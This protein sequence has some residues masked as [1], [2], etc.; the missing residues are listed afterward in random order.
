ME[1]HT[2]ILGLCC[3]FCGERKSGL[4]KHNPKIDA[5][6]KAIYNE[7]LVHDKDIYPEHYCMSCYSKMYRYKQAKTKHSTFKMSQPPMVKLFQP[8]CNQCTVCGLKAGEPSVRLSEPTPSGFTEQEETSYEHDELCTPEPMSELDVCTVD[9]S[10][11][12]PVQIPEPTPSTSGYKDKTSVDSLAVEKSNTLPAMSGE[13]DELFVCKLM[14]E[15]SECAVAPV[16]NS[17]NFSIQTENVMLD[18]TD[19][20]HI[21]FENLSQV[22]IEKLAYALGKSQSCHVRSDTMELS[23]RKTI[24][25]MLK[26]DIGMY[27][28]ERNPVL[29]GFLLGVTNK[30]LDFF[31]NKTEPPEQQTM[32]KICKTVESIMNLSAYRVLLPLHFR[33]TL[34]LYSLTGSKLALSILSSSTA[35]GSY[36]T[37]KKFLS[38]LGH[39]SNNTPFSKDEIYAFD[40]NQILHRSWSVNLESKFRCHI[41]TMV[42]KFESKSDGSFQYRHDLKPGLW[43]LVNNPDVEEVRLLDKSRNVK[44]NHYDQ[45]LYPYLVQAITDVAK[46]QRVKSHDDGKSIFS[47]EI[48][49][50][51]IKHDHDQKF[52]KCHACGNEEVP[53]G[54]RNCS[55]CNCNLKQ[56]ELSAKGLSEHG[57][58]EEKKSTAKSHH[59]KNVRVSFHEAGPNVFSVQYESGES[60]VAATTEPM[61]ASVCP[62]VFV[63]PC[64][65]EACII[66]LRNIGSCAGVTRY[67]GTREFTYVCCDGSPY[68]LCSRIILSTY[69]CSS[70]GENVKKDAFS[71]HILGHEKNV[72]CELYREFDWVLL[73]PGPGHIEMNMVKSYVE[74][75]WDIFWKSLVQLLNFK[76][77]NA[78]KAAKKVSDHHKGWQ[79]CTIAREALV[80]EL[81]TP[82]VR[83]QLNSPTPDLS[84][85]TF[86]KF[87]MTDVKD[88]TY[89]MTADLV[90]ELL[91]AIFMY[92][93]GIRN[94]KTELAFSARAKVAKLWTGRHHPNYREIEMADS[95]S[96]ARM[97]ADLRNE[98]LK[99]WSINTSSIAGTSQG[100]DFKLEEINR[101][102]QAW[103]PKVPSGHDWNV[104]CNNFDTLSQLKDGTLTQLGVSDPKQTAHKQKVLT[105]EV[106]A[107]RALLREHQYLSKPREERGI[108][109]LAGQK[110]SD[111]LIN[112]CEQARVKRSKFYDA[113]ME[114]EPLRCS[115]RAT[116]QFKEHP[117]FV[118]LEE[119]KE[120][121]SLNKLT[122]PELKGVIKDKLNMVL[123]SEAKYAFE[124]VLQGNLA[125]H[126]TAGKS[127]SSQKVRLVKSDY[128]DM[129]NELN[130]YLDYQDNLITTQE[131]GIVEE[132]LDDT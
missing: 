64:S 1:E 25:S 36:T 99:C 34:L 127:S 123:E 122:I 128:V 78:L 24:D 124:S 5:L 9:I 47:D 12:A 26:L 32:Y 131:L 73:I 110:L 106:D 130:E 75:T 18:I 6:F 28:R 118:T 95:I 74:L 117:V 94:E 108:F 113:F 59:P 102:T 93:E 31:E 19:L 81:L 40:N 121:Q 66:V 114:T 96:L 22:Q 63:N 71:V 119:E 56:S 48:D 79:L 52:N 83:M 43:M 129:L 67:G 39:E 116:I 111:G 45:H 42:V 65:Y 53:K 61:N 105:K 70:C 86:L 20:E 92:R 82:W 10:P 15:E 41:V 90:F 69:V 3:R 107:F 125:V 104:V 72:A 44:I 68:V 115:S 50:L 35:H 29:I 23:S 2:R 80:K 54:K 88:Q 13:H 76:S 38:G 8:H 60:S 4:R 57:T 49:D 62:P 46:E 55:S 109:S 21:S 7:K 98:V 85:G 77:E 27:V 120:Y 16:T 103:L 17:K 11:S 126:E 100:P 33:D 51:V 87:V 30:A 14:D 112:F 84:P 89:A 101:Q 132:D 58:W 37:V 91:D 97:P